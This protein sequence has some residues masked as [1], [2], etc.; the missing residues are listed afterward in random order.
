VCLPTATRILD[1]LPAGRRRPKTPSVDRS[2][3]IRAGG[4]GE[5]LT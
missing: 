3:I 1:R 2:V 4:I 5:F